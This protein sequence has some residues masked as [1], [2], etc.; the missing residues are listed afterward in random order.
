V[1][2][3]IARE[4]KGDGAASGAAKHIVSGKRIGDVDVDQRWVRRG[5]GLPK[6]QAMHPTSVLGHF[7]TLARSEMMSVLP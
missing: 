3:L 2:L 7:R 1:I 4:P 5:L 6:C